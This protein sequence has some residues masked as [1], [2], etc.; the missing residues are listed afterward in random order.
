M[1]VPSPVLD[2]RC[3]AALAALL[4]KN[5]TL[6]DVRY[7]AIDDDGIRKEVEERLEANRTAAQ[8]KMSEKVP[9]PAAPEPVSVLRW[10]DGFSGAADAD[11]CEEDEAEEGSEQAAP[12]AERAA[13]LNESTKERE[14]E[15]EQ[16]CT[17]DTIDI[18]FD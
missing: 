6:A 10:R 7:G 13:E 14:K 18:A 16:P 17:V 8:L 11:S 2:Q 12:A 3:A 1:K 4:Q 15:V 5:R 9:A